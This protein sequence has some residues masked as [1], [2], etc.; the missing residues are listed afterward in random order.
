M[1][2]FLNNAK[3]KEKEIALA[4]KGSTTSPG[5]KA[6]TSLPSQLSLGS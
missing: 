2:H 3:R 5:Y 4:M 6:T 1:I